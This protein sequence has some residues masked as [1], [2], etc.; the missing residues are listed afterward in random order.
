MPSL[1]TLPPMGTNHD[2]TGLPLDLDTAEPRAAGHSDRR[3]SG[4]AGDADIAKDTRSCWPPGLPVPLNTNLM[5]AGT[6]GAAKENTCPP[7]LPVLLKKTR[8]RRG[9]RR[10]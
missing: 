8:V 10:C 9:C 6:A 7:G 1:T 3:D 5:S 4:L 2:I